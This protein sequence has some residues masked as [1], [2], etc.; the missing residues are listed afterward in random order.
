MRLPA[1]DPYTLLACIVLII[2]GYLM[3][4]NK[5]GGDGCWAYVLEVEEF[6]RSRGLFEEYW[7][8]MEETFGGMPSREES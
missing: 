4:N 3:G 5:T 6:I 2:V 7:S 1:V 8:Y